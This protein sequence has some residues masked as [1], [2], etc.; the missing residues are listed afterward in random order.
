MDYTKINANDQFDLNGLCI[1]GCNATNLIYTF[2]IYMLIATQWQVFSNSSYYYTSGASNNDL[3]IKKNLFSDYPNQVYWKVELVL[4]QYNSP[5][6]SY[7]GYSS[8]QVY[9][10]FPPLPGK[11]DI[12]PKNG[13]TTTLFNLFCD[14]WTD[15]SGTIKSYDFYGKNFYF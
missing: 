1:V 15:N 2:N 14:Q 11:C 7:F 10:N 6:E 9:V 4:Q 13:S 3:T 12:T 8:M 5:N